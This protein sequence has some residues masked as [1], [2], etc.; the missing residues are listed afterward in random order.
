MAINIF[1]QF[2]KSPWGRHGQYSQ[3]FL[4]LDPK[5]RLGVGNI[6]G[7]VK[8]GEVELWGRAGLWFL[9]SDDMILWYMSSAK[10]N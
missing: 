1:I 5:T 8:Q 7:V 4:Y 10:E 6:V 2:K 9:R 3:E